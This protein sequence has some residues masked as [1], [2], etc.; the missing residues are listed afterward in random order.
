M[1]QHKLIYN[2]KYFPNKPGNKV[3]NKAK[4]VDMYG[5]RE[6]NRPE[7]KL[8]E[9][10]AVYSLAPNEIKKFR[11]D[12]ASYLLG[13]YGFLEDVDPRNLDE[14]IKDMKD[15]EYHCEICDFETDKAV[16]LTGH[17][18]SHKLSDEAQ[19]ILDE[20]PEAGPEAFVVGA[21]FSRSG[22]I[23][24]KSADEM[25]GIPGDGKTDNNDVEWYGDGVQEQRR[26]G[27]MRPTKRKDS[28]L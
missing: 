4:V 20:I 8:L 28:A 24:I 19:K 5:A 2:P 7:G 6:N 18:R 9:K 21:E 12:V 15:K 17:M 1:A 14:L 25:E 16:A 3:R 23:E 26:K 10:P 13:K 27:G 11:V 22:Q